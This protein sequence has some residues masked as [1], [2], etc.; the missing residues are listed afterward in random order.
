MYFSSEDRTS[1]GDG[2]RSEVTP[3]ICVTENL[4]TEGGDD[5]VDGFINYFKGES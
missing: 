2:E 3:Q 4:R 1:I 5:V